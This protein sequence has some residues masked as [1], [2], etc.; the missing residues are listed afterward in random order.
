M[1]QLL[2]LSYS[3]LTIASC[4]TREE[5]RYGGQYPTEFGT[6]NP[7][8]NIK[9]ETR[10]PFNGNTKFDLGWIPFGDLISKDDNSQRDS[11]EMEI[12]KT[13]LVTAAADNPG[14]IVEPLKQVD[15]YRIYIPVGSREVVLTEQEGKGAHKFS[16]YPVPPMETPITLHI[17][18]TEGCQDQ[19]TWD[20][21]GKITRNNLLLQVDFHWLF[22][23]HK[24]NVEEDKSICRNDLESALKGKGDFNPTNPENGTVKNY[25]QIW[26]LLVKSNIKNIDPLEMYPQLKSIDV[27][28][29]VAGVRK[30][31]GLWN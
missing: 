7:A 29:Q 16:S 20:M 23:A 9:F 21:I 22:T 24:S 18:G 15:H 31:R 4:G 3:I 10:A 14:T 12:A 25:Y 8:I 27:S 13:F 30:F 28:V 5:Q 17:N 26:Y 1:K 6:D 19:L 2:L 11:V